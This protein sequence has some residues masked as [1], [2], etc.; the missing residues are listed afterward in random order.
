MVGPI[1]LC[2]SDTERYEINIE[3][4]SHKERC[5]DSVQYESEQNSREGCGVKLSYVHKL[6]HPNSGMGCQVALVDVTSIYIQQ[7]MIDASSQE[8]SVQ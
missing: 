2:L 8:L 5:A 4:K 1:K 6:T 7:Q 3:Y